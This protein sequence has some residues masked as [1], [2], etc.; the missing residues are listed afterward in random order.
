MKIFLEFE[1]YPSGYKEHGYYEFNIL[2]CCAPTNL[3]LIV[4]NGIN[5]ENNVFTH[6]FQYSKIVSLMEVSTRLQAGIELHGKVVT[7]AL[8]NYGHLYNVV[9][10]LGEDATD[11]TWKQYDNMINDAK[12]ALDIHLIDL[13]ELHQ[14]KEYLGLPLEECIKKLLLEDEIGY[15]IHTL[16]SIDKDGNIL[17]VIER[18][19]LAK[20]S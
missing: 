6:D 5:E 18:D 13:D 14:S 3:W 17:N 12:T 10:D 20:N 15:D 2:S 16:R 1:K 7:I 8:G 11:W 9:L 4:N 19:N